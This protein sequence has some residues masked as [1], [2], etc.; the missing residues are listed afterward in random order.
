MDEAGSKRRD[1]DLRHLLEAESVDLLLQDQR[2]VDAPELQ[3]RRV[4]GDRDRR[5][6]QALADQH[7]RRRGLG[8][9]GDVAGSDLGDGSVALAAMDVVD[10]GR[11]VAAARAVAIDRE[12]NLCRGQ[13]R[14]ARRAGRR[15]DEGEEVEVDVSSRPERP[16]C[17]W[18]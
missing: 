10:G 15:G 9:G 18:R 1:H 11:Q 7:A 16:C 5:Q 14:G 8:R 13:E 6:Q 2:R 4:V 17:R 3:D 12:V